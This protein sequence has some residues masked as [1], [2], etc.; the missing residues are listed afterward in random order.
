MIKDFRQKEMMP[1]DIY[2][3]LRTCFCEF[4]KWIITYVA[5]FIKYVSCKCIYVRAGSCNQCGRCCRHVYLRE[6]GKIVSSFD[7]CL[8]I[9]RSDKRLKRFCARGTNEF[10]EIY[11]S[12][13]VVGRDN[14][15]GDYSNRPMLCR[16]YPSVT[17]LL[18]DAVPKEDCGFYFVNRFTRKRVV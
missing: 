12:C 8:R 4:F 14:K 5:G 7:D 15:C 2:L 9:I 13:D 3:W 10:G 6:G 1:H 17:M 18:Y 11:F 16:S